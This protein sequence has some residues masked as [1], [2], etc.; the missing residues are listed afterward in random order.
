VD[1][2]GGIREI[3]LTAAGILCRMVLTGFS[4]RPETKLL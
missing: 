2:H 1:R 3:N 4:K